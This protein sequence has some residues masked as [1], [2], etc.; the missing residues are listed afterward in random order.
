ML[1]PG[2]PALAICIRGDSGNGVLPVCQAHLWPA[3]SPW[4]PALASVGSFALSAAVHV[5][6]SASDPLQAAHYRLIDPAGRWT[7][8][9]VMG[10]TLLAFGAAS[11]SNPGVITPANHQD[12]MRLYGGAAVDKR[13]QC[14]TCN[15]QRPARSRHCTICKR[16]TKAQADTCSR[17][18][19][20]V[21]YAAMLVQ[22]VQVHC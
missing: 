1:E 17:A 10:I 8:A 21:L 15:W 20:C 18:S 13:A 6:A 9:A 19:P 3:T 12:H 14:N 11:V 7:G 16:Y 4:S 2:W 22:I 5:D